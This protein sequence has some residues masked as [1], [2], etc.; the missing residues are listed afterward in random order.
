MHDDAVG[1]VVQINKGRIIRNKQTSF[2]FPLLI[3]KAR[4]PKLNQSIKNNRGNDKTKA[5]LWRNIHI[6]QLHRITQ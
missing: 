6:D 2:F 4:D 1:L 5:Q 3:G